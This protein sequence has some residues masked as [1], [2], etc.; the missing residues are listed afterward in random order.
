MQ[1]SDHTSLFHSYPLPFST[2]GDMYSGVPTLECASMVF[3]DSRR[4]RPRSPTFTV[5]FSV[6]K[7]LAGFKSRCMMRLPCMCATAAATCVKYFQMTRSSN[8]ASRSRALRSCRFRSPASAYSNTRMSWLS[9]MKP[10]RYRMMLSW[11][12]LRTSWI[13]FRHFSRDRSSMMSNMAI[14]FSATDTP[15]AR[16]TALYTVLNLPF[17][18]AFCTSYTAAS[19]PVTTSTRTPSRLTAALITAAALAA[20]AELPP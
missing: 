8:R 19:R 10:S 20:V 4:P 3:S 7:M 18:I 13:S 17:P 15:S 1:P 5:P 14:C 6:R 16:R 12:R 11:S 9:S 2:S